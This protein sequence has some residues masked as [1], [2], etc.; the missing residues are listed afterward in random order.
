MNPTANA[1]DRRD[2]VWS[3]GWEDPLEE[4]M[5]IHS[6]IL[7]W[8]IPWTEEPGRLQ[9][10]RSQSWRWL[11]QHSTHQWKES[12][13]ELLTVKCFRQNV[14]HNFRE[15]PPS[16]LPL[17]HRMRSE[18]PTGDFLQIPLTDTTGTKRLLFDL[19]YLL[20]SE[21]EVEE[22]SKKK[23]PNRCFCL[24]WQLQILS[25]LRNSHYKQ[26][27]WQ[28]KVK[29]AQ[30][31]PILCH[32]WTIDR[33]YGILQARILAWVAIPFRGSFKPRDR[34]Q[35]SHIASGFFIIPFFLPMMM[36][37]IKTIVVTI[38]HALTCIT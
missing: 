20:N 29:V 23:L 12:Q 3:L 18:P 22:R 10:M 5:A 7:A 33:V 6:S 34:T 38:Y 17:G 13:K 14:P 24:R 27:H 31:C 15:S 8:R 26:Y 25:R 4:G 9:S 32:P 1:G 30:W 35:V 28:W 2:G 37:V 21:E 19:P 11:K 36:I 16:Y